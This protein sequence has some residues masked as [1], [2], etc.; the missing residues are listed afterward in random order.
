[1]EPQPTLTDLPFEVLDLIYKA[2][3]SKPP[4]GYWRQYSVYHYSKDKLSLAETSEYLG[5]AFAYH[6]RDVYKKACYD[7]S[8]FFISEEAWPVILSL[9]GSTTVEYVGCPGCFWS[10]KVA[11]AVGQYCPNLKTV[12]FQVY[13][14]NGDILL[15]ILHKAKNAIRN[16]NFG[17]ATHDRSRIGPNL[18]HKIPELPLLSSLTINSFLVEEA[19]EIQR[20]VNI[21][22]LYLQTP[23]FNKI[24]EPKPLNLFKVCS[25]LKKLRLLMVV[26][27]HIISEI[28]ESETI[29]E[30]PALE[31]FKL[32]CSL[33]SMEFPRCPKL[34]ILN[35]AASNCH[36]EGLVCRSVLKQGPDLEKLIVDSRPS[37][38]DN[39]SL[40]E[41]IRKFKKLRYFDVPIRKMKFDLGFV[42]ELINTLRENGVTEENPLELVLD[43]VSKIRWMLHWVR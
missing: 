14:D 24:E 23:Y 21:E 29:P 30:F 17:Y 11:K 42:T 35:I 13:F 27:V 10:P 19:Y 25:A 36:I 6:S 12:K 28:D 26:R 22:E 1:M 40:L 34:K 4:Y 37:Q 33:I 2:L 41:V 3:A 20:F 39:D 16:L 38:F 32:S 18:M 5:Q 7:S 9:C 8:Y 31:H 43:E 15:S